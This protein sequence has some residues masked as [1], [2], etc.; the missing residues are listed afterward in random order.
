[1]L[2]IEVSVPV[3]LV[4]R[5]PSNNVSVDHEDYVSRLQESIRTAHEVARDVLKT[6]QINMKSDYDVKIH[7]REYAVGDLIYVFVV[8]CAG[9]NFSVSS[10]FVF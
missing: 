7:T 1:M 8:E 4:F 10:G 5:P 6:H 2:G 9:N 3:D